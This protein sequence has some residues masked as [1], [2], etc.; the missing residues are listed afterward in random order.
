[1][2]DLSRNQNQ[3]RARENWVSRNALAWLLAAQGFTIL[4]LFVYLPIW[5]PP[6][7]LFALAWRVQIFRGAWPFPNS[8][9]K[10]VLGVSVLIGLI[11]HYAGNIGV[12]PLVALLVLAFVLKLLEVRTRGDVLIILY[13]GFIAVAAQF[14]FFQ[15]ILIA[16]YGFISVL[17]LL[18]AWNAVYRSEALSI[19]KQIK[20]SAN[21]L[22][23]SVPLMLVLFLVMPRV[24]SLWQVPIPQET[25]QTGF[26]DSMSPGDFS[27]LS[28]SDAIAF[29]VTFDKGSNQNA[30]PLRDQ[31]YWRGLVLDHFDGR[32]WKH[33]DSPFSKRSQGSQKVPD[34]LD[35]EV[36]K[37]SKGVR[38]QVLMEPHQQR[39][40]F[41]LMAPLTANS[42]A[43]RLWF[44][45]DYLLKSAQPIAARTQ[46]EAFSNLDYRFAKHGLSEGERKLN[47]K[48]PKKSNP[49]ALDLAQAWLAQNL[50]QSQII[51]KA[52][53][54][55][56]QSFT[57]TLR[58]PPLGSNSVDEFLFITKKGFC[59]HFSSSFVFLMRA[60]GIPARVVVGY[61][62]GEV[63]PIEN[64]I[65]VKQK[66]AHAWAE[67]WSPNA[68][69][70]RVDPTA[71]VSP[72]RIERGINESLGKEDARLIRPMFSAAWFSRLQ[73]QWDA[74]S[75]SWHK[76][77]L[78]YDDR[79]QKGL[80]ERWF[81]GA[82]AWRIGAFFVLTLGSAM[83]LYFIVL[84][85]KGSVEYAYPEQKAYARL[86]KKLR[87][88]GVE[89]KPE[90]APHTF[91]LRI[92]SA[93]PAIRSEL[94]ELA[95]LLE[96]LIYAGNASNLKQL[97]VHVQRFKV[98]AT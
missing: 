6:V 57:Y 46:Y 7:W 78:S 26:S 95:E 83:L 41:T 96:T 80:F 10:G 51:E 67:V 68:G 66:D 8:K 86:L 40:L 20:S 30:L 34:F 21:I 91:C 25:G 75:Y 87:V 54:R 17:L 3:S 35:V 43:N 45:S 14:L 18:S 31:W 92:A 13:V 32:T 58:P 48:I 36:S 23:Q 55:Y 33:T 62:G 84:T 53:D 72:L 22:L 1:M 39:W 9:I 85:R 76:W 27:N 73:L 19:S 93:H 15:T 49:R 59:E 11:A 2:S 60:A 50:S 37:A 24:G 61:Q 42:G 98:P 4:P 65:I 94:L 77:V 16:M 47:L 74:F 89:P 81:G 97:E 52:L 90:E 82:E 79:S 56:R 44:T 5:V 71:A 12:E 38:Y 88:L 63:N 29:R 69:W 64:Y 28:Q 70:Q